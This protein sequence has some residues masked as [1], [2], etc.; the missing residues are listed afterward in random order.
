MGAVSP[1]VVLSDRTK[2]LLAIVTAAA[3]A[4]EPTPGDKDLAAA[5]RAAGHGIGDARGRIAYELDRLETAGLLSIPGRPNRR[6][7]VIPGTGHRTLP[8]TPSNVARVRA[9]VIATA[10]RTANAVGWPKPTA[11]S[12]ASY[13]EAVRRRLFGMHEVRPRA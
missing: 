11:A 4:N 12:A 8:R 10:Q 7:F 3:V 13:D 6:V 5:L 9:S 2:A 1:S